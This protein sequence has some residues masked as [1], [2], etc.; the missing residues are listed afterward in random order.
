MPTGLL[1]R[2]QFG[3][4]FERRLA[5]LDEI[6]FQRFPHH[7][8]H[9]D[10]IFKVRD[11]NRAYEEVTGVS[12]LGLFTEKAEGEAVTYD[13]VIQLYDKRLTQ[14]TYGSGTQASLELLHFDIDGPLQRGAECLAR[15]GAV[16]AEMTVWAV[17]NNSFTSETVPDGAAIFSATHPL[18]T[19]AVFSNLI[20]SDFCIGAVEDLLNKYADMVD[21][22]G[23]LI[24][25]QPKTLVIPPELR[26]YAQMLFGSELIPDLET[27]AN[28]GLDG[29]KTNVNMSLNQV[30]SINP[31]RGLGINFFVSPYLT[32]ADNWFI[33][34][35]QDESP[36]RVFWGIRPTTD[37][38]IDFDSGNA[39]TKLI[40][41]LSAGAFDWRPMV[42]G[43]GA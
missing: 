35:S 5:Y 30:N 4:L 24:A 18:T 23:L 1:L 34:G 10:Q 8:M 15:A 21:D 31:M 41:S 33:M 7:A 17:L 9:F 28:G 42:G 26:I 43:Q 14:V 20:S 32:D 11:S 25:V 19:G 40:Y 36:L 29:Y 13:S 16:S 6:I 37:H 27:G 22:R 12:G 2:P 38:A 3:D 39:K